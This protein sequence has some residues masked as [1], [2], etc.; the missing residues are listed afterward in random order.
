MAGT[1][2]TEA[3]LRLSPKPFDVSAYGGS[4]DED[5]VAGADL[6]R[7]GAPPS[8]RTGLEAVCQ[9]LNSSWC[10]PFNGFVE[11]A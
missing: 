9:G 7:S 6:G 10:V 1:A 2:S 8:S 3:I 5:H 4:G 11:A